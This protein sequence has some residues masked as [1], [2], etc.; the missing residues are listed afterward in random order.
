MKDIGPVQVLRNAIVGGGYT[1]H[2]IKLLVLRKSTLTY[3][4]VGGVQL[5]DKKLYVTLE[6]PQT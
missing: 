2:H 4:G 6:W 1:D 5:L 3:E